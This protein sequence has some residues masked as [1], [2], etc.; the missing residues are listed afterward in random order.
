[1]EAPM[2][3]SYFIGIDAT[4]SSPQS[5][6]MGDRSINTS[7]LNNASPAAASYAL[8]VPNPAAGTGSG[9]YYSLAWTVND[10]HQKVGDVALTDGSVQ[11]L[12]VNGLQSALKDSTNGVTFATGY[13]GPRLNFPG[14]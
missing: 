6:I 5:I 12:T 3:R 7:T 4:E 8:G 1:M 13:N 10:L 14:P 11:Q 9:G 2:K